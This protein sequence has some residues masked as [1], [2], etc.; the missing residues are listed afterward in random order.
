MSDMHLVGA[1]P[2]ADET[3]RQWLEK[4]IKD[5]SHLTT[6]I[7]ARDQY[8]GASRT[9]LDS[10]LAG[11]YFL[12]T[13]AGGQGVDPRRSKLEAQVRAY[14]EKIEGTERHGYDESFVETRS[15]WQLKQACQT[16]I[17]ENAIVVVYGKPGVGKTHG[18]AH[19]AISNMQSTMPIQLLCG[20]N[21]TTRY[22]LQKLA[23]EV[24]LD[25][26]TP[27]ARL[28]DLVAEKLRRSPRPLF[29]DQA[30]FL[31]ESAL[32]SICH[33]WDIAKIPIVLA[34]TQLLYDVFFSS[35]MTEDVRAQLSRRVSLHYPL[36]ELTPEQAKAI[37]VKALGE[38][39]TDEVIARLFNMTGSI[40]GHLSMALRRILDTK[41]RNKKR[42]DSGEVTI[43]Q[44]I[45]SA[46][47]K[48]MV[49]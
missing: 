21:I 39:V 38:D 31:K 16:A 27:T 48:L 24:G 34:G 18:L 12:P 17:R 4:H 46:G 10:Y 19:F 9:A 35:R 36:Q 43:E 30:N 22:F 47:A 15:W 2:Q 28:E 37:I 14:K 45:I 42:L 20:F 25:E 33:I 40:H 1:S 3:L 5:H 32:G 23:R 44:I 41:K 29:V 8:I 49:S 26:R 13:E 6:T 11:T 7:L